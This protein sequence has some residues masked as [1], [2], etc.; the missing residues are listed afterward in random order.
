[1]KRNDVVDISNSDV[2]L[3]SDDFSNCKYWKSIIFVNNNDTKIFV[4]VFCPLKMQ[5]YALSLNHVDSSVLLSL[6]WLKL[7][8]VFKGTSV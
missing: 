6:I 7:A 4:F 3:S 8:L 1:M 2:T 5:K